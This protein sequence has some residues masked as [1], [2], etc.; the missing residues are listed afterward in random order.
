[1]ENLIISG[2][3]IIDI[4]ALLWFV[5]VWI[6]YIIFTRNR[7]NNERSGLIAEMN[8]VRSDWAFELIKRDN[9]IMDSQLINGLI[10]KET[11]FASTTMLIIASTL[12]LMG[13]G[14]EA[15]NLFQ[16]IPFAQTTSHILWEL[17]VL[18]LIIIFMFAFFKFTWSIRQHSYCAVLIGSIPTAKQSETDKSII[19]AHQLAKLTSLAANNFNDGL[20]AYYFALAE[21]SWFYHP[22]LFMFT[23]TWVV[24]VLYRREFHS[25]ALAIL[26]HKEL[27]KHE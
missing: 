15:L 14:E 20:R 24:L 4:V 18:V 21:L 17:K 13:V 22:L 5:C 7:S 6:G 27:P 11:F 1:M 25:N 3:S 9:R 8:V 23:T 16:N 2:I 12:A 19:K 26:K 10:S